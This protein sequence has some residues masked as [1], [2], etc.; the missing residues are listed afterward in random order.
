M[1]RH[2]FIPQ[3]FNYAVNTLNLNPPD[4]SW[5]DLRK[6]SYHQN[7]DR[8]I[9]RLQLQYGPDRF[10]QKL[11]NFKEIGALPASVISYH[12]DFF[13]QIRD[14]FVQESYY[15]ALTGACALGERIYSHLIFDLR[16]SYSA[17]DFYKD[18]KNKNSFQNWD[19]A[20]K[21][22]ET[23]GV[24]QEPV[25]SQEFLHF[26]ADIYKNLRNDALKALRHLSKI[27]ELQFSGHNRPCMI[28]NTRFIKKSFESIP[29]IQR[30]YLPQCPLV[31]P[32][33]NLLRLN[34]GGWLVFDRENYEDKEVSDREYASLRHVAG[35]SNTLVSTEI[36][37]SAEIFVRDVL[38]NEVCQGDSI[39]NAA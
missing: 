29:F 2:V 19:K 15:T 11:E 25:I 36:P 26:G 5:D 4:E 24:F 6:E 33:H 23:W 37:W 8:I 14:S 7:Q 31:S 16:N 17:P 1:K 32:D 34:N 10:F 38:G 12:N 18:V 39:F 35:V 22:L 13:R 27:I 28:E 20:I 21:C 9:Q 30:Y 3:D